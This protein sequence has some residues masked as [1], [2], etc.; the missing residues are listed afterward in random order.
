MGTNSTTPLSLGA[1]PGSDLS[2]T[3]TAFGLYVAGPGTRRFD[4]VE[5]DGVPVPEPASVL[6]VGLAALGL[7]CLRRR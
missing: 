5:I 2:G 7:T 6:L 1:A 3:I 4:T